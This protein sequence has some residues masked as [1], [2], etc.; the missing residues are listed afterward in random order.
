M[1]ISAQTYEQAAL[2]DPDGLW[3]LERGRLRQKPGLTFEQFGAAV[4]L[5][6][7]LT[8]QL[9]SHGYLVAMNEP[10]PQPDGSYAVFEQHGGAMTPVALPGVRIDLDRLV[11][12]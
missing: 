4:A 12:E 7:E 5:V 2:E 3:E 1:S 8:R 9:T 10:R 6:G 11:A